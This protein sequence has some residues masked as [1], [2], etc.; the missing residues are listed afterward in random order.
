MKIAITSSGNTLQSVVDQRFGRCPFLVIYDSE[1]KGVEFL[2]NPNQN[3][4]DG[5]GPA[6]VQMI[7]SRNVGKIISGEFGQKV[8]PLLDS[9][10]IQMI[11]IK[12]PRQTIK[13]IIEMISH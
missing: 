8:K 3:A 7:A 12:E 11:I 1:S 5:A 6:T 13:D 10:K 4:T 9:L 2:P